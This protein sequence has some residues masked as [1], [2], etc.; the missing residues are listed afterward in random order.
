M[1]LKF[2][3]ITISGGVSTGKNT[4]LNNLK[5]YLIPLGWKFTS[6]GQLL[7]DFA[8]EYV[9]PLASLADK[10]FHNMLDDRTKRLL[11]QEGNYVIEAWL[12]GFM[13]RNLKDTLR[14]LLICDDDAL[15]IDRVANRDKVSIDN[16]KKYIRERED[17]NF[18][19]WK[20]IYGDYN[21][22]DKKYYHLIID[23]YSS[24]Q[25]ETVGKVLDRLGYSAEK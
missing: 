23:T 24:G 22:F 2:R 3:N 15:R 21:F 10:K 1:K 4:L 8:K 7:R 18:K 20:R 19:E 13:A 16:A 12:A 25:L 17:V 9:Q 5:P 11:T 14:V 6:G